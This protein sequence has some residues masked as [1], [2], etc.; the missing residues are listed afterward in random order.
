MR[1]HHPPVFQSA[2]SA[3]RLRSLLCEVTRS[4]SVYLKDTVRKLKLPLQVFKQLLDQLFDGLMLQLRSIPLGLR[5]DSWIHREYLDLA[6]LQR[7]AAVRQLHDNQRSLAPDVRKIAPTKVF[8]SS[9]TMNAA[10]AAFWARTLKDPS[11][12]LPFRSA[13]FHKDRRGT[14]RHPG[15]DLRRS[16]QGL[17]THRRVGSQAQPLELV[18][19]DPVWLWNIGTLS[20]SLGQTSLCRSTPKFLSTLWQ[21]RTSTSLSSPARGS[22]SRLPVLPG[23]R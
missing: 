14:P 18:R 16:A 17:C 2:G 8:R 13:A 1:L 3:L 20:N 12:T 4:S 10:F 7:E 19:V 15:R 23:G 9:V 11:L 22:R 6:D 5:V 21:L